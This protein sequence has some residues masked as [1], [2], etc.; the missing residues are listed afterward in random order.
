LKL[1][2]EKGIALGMVMVL[3][4]VGLAIAAGVLFIVL[5]WATAVGMTR[6]YKTAYE[7]GVGGAEVTFAAISARDIPFITD[8]DVTAGAWVDN[9]CRIAK[10]NTSTST[11]PT[12]CDNSVAINPGDASSFDLRFDLGNYR[13]YTKI[14]DTVEGNSSASMGLDIAPGTV[15]TSTGQVEVV[16]RPYLYTIEVL[17]QNQSRPEER[18]RISILYQY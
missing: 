5:R 6:Q 4:L 18:S 9:N 13:V 14:I 11:W 3:S 2:D 7:A 8:L 16:S 17:S 10:L 1:S 12:G 15:N